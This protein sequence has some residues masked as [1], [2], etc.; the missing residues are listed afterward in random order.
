M[1]CA[2][3]LLFQLFALSHL[4][5]CAF[6]VSG[7]DSNS[8]APPPSLVLSGV[9]RL[10]SLVQW[11]L[12]RIDW[13]H[14]PWLPPR[15]LRPIPASCFSFVAALPAYW[16]RA[17]D[18]VDAL[19]DFTRFEGDGVS[20]RAYAY[21]RA[22][23]ERYGERYYHA[24]LAWD[25][26]GVEDDLDGADDVD[27]DPDPGPALSWAAVRALRAASASGSAPRWVRD[28]AGDGSLEGGASVSPSDYS[29]DDAL[30][31]LV[32]RFGSLDGAGAMDVDAPV[33]GGSLR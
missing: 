10:G 12:F 2:Q 17:C 15:L 21:G 13:L 3:R 29:D 25:D 1:V 5:F 31:S 4:Q 18:Y 14:G 28:G 22:N 7:A 27:S 8:V 6:L 11:L 23:L 20:L 24:L 33:G 19:W 32:P 9:S 26:A 30:G 16:D